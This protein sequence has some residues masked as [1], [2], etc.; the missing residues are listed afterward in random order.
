MPSWSP[1]RSVL[2][3][4]HHLC[5]PHPSFLVVDSFPLSL[6]SAFKIHPFRYNL[7]HFLT[8]TFLLLCLMSPSLR[9]TH[10]TN[11]RGSISDS[12]KHWRCSLQCSGMHASQRQ[13]FSWHKCLV[14]SRLSILGECS[15]GPQSVALI[16]VSS[17]SAL[18]SE[19]SCLALSL[20]FFL[21]TL[22]SWWAG[23][24]WGFPPV[25]PR[26]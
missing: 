21:L 26:F 5:P 2:W 9:I 3:Y 13:A 20:W 8:V 16:W 1:E 11:G 7:L 23:S 10:Q 14:S 25:Y 6:P 24:I 15:A 22:E 17:P 12:C 4:L 19:L 18:L